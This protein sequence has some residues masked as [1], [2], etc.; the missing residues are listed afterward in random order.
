M[1]KQSVLDTI[2][3]TPLIK[4]NKLFPKKDVEIFVKLEYLNP[5]GSIKDRIAKYIIEEAEASGKLQ[6]G[7]TI[8]ENTSGNT[9]AAAAM[10]AAAKGYRCI[11]TM[12]DKV[13]EEKQNA[14]KAF[15]ADIHICPTSATPDSP[16]HYVNTAKRIAEETPNS[17]RINQYDNPLNPE[18]HYKSTGP[19][20]WAQMNEKIDVFVYSSSTG[21]TVSGVGRFL[22]EQDNKIQVIV[23]D[24][25]GSVFYPY[26]KTGQLPENASCT[27]YL[28]GI[29]EDHITKAID[30]S[31]I[32]DMMQVDDR[33]AFSIN[34]QLATEEGVLAG[35][36][37]G[38]NVWAAIEIAKQATKPLRIVTIMCDSG[39]KYLSKIY[40]PCW[41]KENNL[42][43]KALH[44]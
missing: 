44:T 16:D 31:V 23:P 14:L 6:P 35:G 22:K 33:D 38:A 34:H 24:P 10:I 29:G 13:S 21:G 41:L 5:S 25:I 9:G 2:G 17:F 11:L 19:E 36:S 39:V 1:N 26:F 37:S 28:E 3:K 27:Y 42:L 20:I 4:L 32:D 8:V 40:N 18:A 7:G 15:G 30:F 12:P 43:K